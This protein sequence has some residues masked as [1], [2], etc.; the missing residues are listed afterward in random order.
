MDIQKLLVDYR[1]AQNTRRI[2]KINKKIMGDFVEYKVVYQNGT[3]PLVQEV[4]MKIYLKFN[5]FITFRKN[6]ARINYLEEDFLFND[7]LPCDTQLK[8]ICED[9]NEDISLTFNN[10]G[11]KDEC[12]QML[13]YYLGLSNRSTPDIN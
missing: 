1:E 10:K 7:K 9:G 12:V 8:I 13:I 5:K 4:K 11:E 6:N 3:G 2:K